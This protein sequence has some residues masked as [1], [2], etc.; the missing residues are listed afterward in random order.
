MFGLGEVTE[1]KLEKLVVKGNWEKIKK[2][3]VHSDTETQ[4]KLA[5][6]CSKSRT[7]DCANILI[8]LLSETNEEVK[9]AVL[10]SMAIVGNNHLITLL[11]EVD[12][13]LP[14]SSKKLHDE[15]QV[16]LNQI[17]QRG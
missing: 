4:I 16:T 14:S 12:R 1:E 8:S 15:I 5:H 3:Y 7:D 13:K 6:A 10:K 17:R 9:M 11:Q 2:S